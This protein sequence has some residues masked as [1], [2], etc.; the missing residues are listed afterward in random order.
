MGVSSLHLVSFSQ[1]FVT[2]NNRCLE[3]FANGIESPDFRSVHV[4]VNGNRSSDIVENANESLDYV[5]EAKK[6][7]D[8]FTDANGNL[9]IAVKD[10]DS[11]DLVLNLP[12][13]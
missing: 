1:V 11:C 2:D 7:C 9:E 6:S 5:A 8:F 10:N 4:F 13:V 3:L 12:G